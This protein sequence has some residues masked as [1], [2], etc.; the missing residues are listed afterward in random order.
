MTI[1][2]ADFFSLSWMDMDMATDLPSVGPSTA[3]TLAVMAAAL[4]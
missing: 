1:N 3:A 4:T 2:N